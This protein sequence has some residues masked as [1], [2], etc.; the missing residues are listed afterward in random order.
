[1]FGVPGNGMYSLSIVSDADVEYT[2]MVGRGHTLTNYAGQLPFDFSVNSSLQ[3]DNL[4]FASNAFSTE[5]LSSI[6]VNAG[7]TF[8]ID[9]DFNSLTGNSIYA[10]AT[11]QSLSFNAVS[12]PATVPLPSTLLLLTTGLGLLKGIGFRK[13]RLLN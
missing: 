7:E 13:K 2:G 11:L 8:L 4:M 12:T 5:S 9:V 3:L 10:S 1:M 6:F